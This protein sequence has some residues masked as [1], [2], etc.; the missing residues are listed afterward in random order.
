MK[1]RKKEIL[2]NQARLEERNHIYRRYGYDSRRAV[3]FILARARP[4]SGRVLE[5]GTGKGRFLVELAKRATRVVTVDT[6]PAEQR[7]ARLNAALAGLGRRIR[8]V[9]ADGAHLPFSDG[10]FD[11]VASMNALH[12]IR[13]LDAVLD[14]MLRVVK[15]GGKIVLADFDAVGFR[16]FDRIHKD[17]GRT[18]ERLPYRWSR[19]A[20][21]LRRAGCKVRRA[22]REHVEVAVAVMPRSGRTPLASATEARP[23]PPVN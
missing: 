19:I 23:T 15:A 3:R 11:A 12:H 9:I 10:S 7:Y 16:I 13:D 17:E 4:L 5:I 2:E 20:A 22:R 6:N 14:E 18:H 1:L 8:F 21:R